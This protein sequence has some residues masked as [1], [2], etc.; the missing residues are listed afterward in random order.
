MT[1]G[2]LQASILDLCRTLHLLCH[3][4]RP[5]RLGSGKWATPISGHAGFTDLVIAGVG[6]VVFAE[7]KNDVHQP[8]PEQMTWMGTL[9]EGGASVFLWRPKQWFDKSIEA[10]LRSLAKPREVSREA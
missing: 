7:L 4:C 9:E 6:G 2:Q 10:T 3:H 1:E 8:T 5:A